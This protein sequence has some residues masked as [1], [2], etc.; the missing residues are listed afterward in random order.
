VLRREEEQTE[1]EEKCAGAGWVEA[2]KG[3]KENAGGRRVFDQVKK[4]ESMNVLYR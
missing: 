2:W 4:D 1:R 3:S